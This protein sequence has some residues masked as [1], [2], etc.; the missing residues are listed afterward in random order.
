MI[1]PS[2]PQSNFGTYQLL[3]GDAELLAV[4]TP[5]VVRVHD[6]SQQEC[7]FKFCFAGEA[8]TLWGTNANRDIL[9]DHNGCAQQS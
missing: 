7:S 3:H 4:E 5:R 9:L 6:L 1:Y 2:L 8:L